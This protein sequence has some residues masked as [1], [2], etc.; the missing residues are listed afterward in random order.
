MNLPTNTIGGHGN[1]EG[2]NTRQTSTIA[3]VKEL[4]Q[5]LNARWT[6]VN[7]VADSIKQVAMFTNLLALNAAI[8][9][10][11]AGEHGRGFS[12]V[13]DEV[14]RLAGQTTD[15]T[16]SI[17]KVVEAIRAES[18]QAVANVE[19]AE[20]DSILESAHTLLQHEV[21][22]LNLRFIAM[23]TALY[24]LKNFITGSMEAGIAP[25]REQIDAVMENSLHMNPDLLAFACACEP[26]VL[27]GRDA[28]YA[29]APRHDSTGRF[30]AYWNRGGGEVIR[31]CLVGYDV[32]GQNDWY[33]LPKKSGRDAFMEPYEY[34]VAGNT[35]LM[36]SFMTPFYVRRQ[37]MGI[38][39]ADYSLAELQQDLAS[40]R[41]FGGTGEFLLL[42]NSGKFVAHTDIAMLGQTAA[43]WPSSAMD[44]I[45][46]GQPCRFR[47]PEKNIYLLQP[48]TV[49]NSDMPWALCLR[50][51]PAA[52]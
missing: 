43:N 27:D 4:I 51:N 2:G 14:R 21:S 1:T 13:A 30:M 10:A 32:P 33:V 19:K 47:D 12:V 23:S 7:A 17:T 29:S 34:T 49:G 38:L 40:N 25:S 8:E 11:R 41:P 22:R 3:Q 42:S 45:R 46:S 26:D 36:T 18:A 44:A 24:G 15:A 39:G 31:E 6:Q 35:I 50:F 16:S 20:T 37:F 48:I 28:E 5:G 52:T 9:A